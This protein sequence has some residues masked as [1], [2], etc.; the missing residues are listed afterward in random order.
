MLIWTTAEDAYEQSRGSRNKYHLVQPQ[1]THMDKA[2]AP[3]SSALG[4]LQKMLM[5]TAEASVT[6]ADFGTCRR[7]S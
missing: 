6:N 2:E 5:H 4:H 3:V 1:K 7:C